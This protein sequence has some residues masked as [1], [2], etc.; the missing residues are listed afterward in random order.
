[1]TTKERLIAARNLLDSL[2]PL[3]GDCGRQCGAACCQPDEMGRGGMYLFP[4]EAACYSDDMDWATIAPSGIVVGGEPL[5]LLTC[6]GSCPRDARPLSCRIFPLTPTTQD[7][8]LTVIPD[9]RAWPVCPL[10]E[11]GISGLSK[12]FVDAVQ[13]AMAL[14]WDDPACRAYFAFVDAQLKDFQS[15]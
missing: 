7:G 10:M 9:I 2:T 3:K 4:G 6:D 8:Q 15:F 5:L 14:L 12:A 1:M 11:Y 13:E